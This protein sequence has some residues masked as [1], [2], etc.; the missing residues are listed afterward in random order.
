MRGNV[1]SHL[2]M[3]T[4]PGERADEHLDYCGHLTEDGWRRP[5]SGSAAPMRITEHPA[6]AQLRDL[7]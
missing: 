1:H 5:Q 2:G 6:M 3:G 4:K 7:I